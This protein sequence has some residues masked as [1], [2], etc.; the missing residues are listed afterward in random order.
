MKAS[1]NPHYRHRFPAE[2]ISSFMIVNLFDFHNVFYDEL[3][4]CSV[5]QSLFP[6]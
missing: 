5:R 2:I 6:V 1:P 4:V 3:A